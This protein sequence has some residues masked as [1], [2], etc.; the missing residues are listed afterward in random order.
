[1]LWKAIGV[2]FVAG[3]FNPFG[4]RVWGEPF[5]FFGASL[6]AVR[7]YLGEVR[8]AELSHASLADAAFWLNLDASS[9]AALVLIVT[10]TV[11]FVLNRR[12]MELGQFFVF[13][14]FIGLGVFHVQELAAMALV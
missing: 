4:W 11:A 9:V 10:A 2:A 3:M 5:R 8:G 6:P 12:R 7:A 13:L 1:A 14:G